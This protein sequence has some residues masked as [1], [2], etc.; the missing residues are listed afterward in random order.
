MSR[1]RQHQ[2]RLSAHP[3]A[4]RHIRAA[5]GWGGLVGFAAVG[6]LSYQAGILPFEVGV[7]ALLG[8]IVGYVVA[9]AIAVHVWRHLAVAEIR[10]AQGVLVERRRPPEEARPEAREA[11]VEAKAGA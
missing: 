4:A 3:R 2:L 1:A 8:G 7:R 5:K 9:W 10:A 11:P 6:L